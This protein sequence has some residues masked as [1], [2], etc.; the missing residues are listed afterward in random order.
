MPV[1]HASVLD[2]CIRQIRAFL[3]STA[4]R[5]RI[6]VTRTIRAVIA[7]ITELNPELGRHLGLSVRT[8]TYCSFAPHPGIAT[9]WDV[10][11]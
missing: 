4:E 8:G 10:K 7:R 5:Q 1:A 3:Q 11:L 2:H 9:E 6:N